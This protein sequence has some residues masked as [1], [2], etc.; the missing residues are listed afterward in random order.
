MYWQYM[1]VAEPYDI[2]AV[3]RF[4]DL[5]RRAYRGAILVGGLV[6]ASLLSNKLRNEARATS[7]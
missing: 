5:W 1:H 3:H 6:A 2:L 7:G 4:D